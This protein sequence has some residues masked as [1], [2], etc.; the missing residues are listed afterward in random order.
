MAGNRAGRPPKT[1]DAKVLA[2][3][4]KTSRE[5]PPAFKPEAGVPSAPRELSKEA[6]AEWNRI[7]PLLREENILALVDLAALV[8]Y[9]DA[10]GTWQK[11]TRVLT[12]KGLTFKTPMNYVQQ[13]PEVSIA[14]QARKQMVDFAREFGLTPSS[15]AKVKPPSKAPDKESP[16]DALDQ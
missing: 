3:T 1:Q 8:A 12:A 13:R 2:G 6:R 15:R 10:Y 7:V 14:H 9:C 4:W 16:W 11:A 5:L